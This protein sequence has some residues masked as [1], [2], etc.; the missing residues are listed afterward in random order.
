MHEL[1]LFINSLLRDSTINPF[2]YLSASSARI[3]S[4]EEEGAFQWITVNY[5][6][7]S[8]AG[9]SVF[10]NFSVT[11]VVHFVAQVE[12]SVGCLFTRTITFEPDDF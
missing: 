4:G 10:F 6:I 8:F 9:Q 5:L 2:S 11:L 7:G 3:L 1:I 12:Q